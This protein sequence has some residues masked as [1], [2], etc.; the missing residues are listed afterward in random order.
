MNNETITRERRCNHRRK[1]GPETIPDNV[2]TPI[3]GIPGN[4]YKK[5]KGLCSSIITDQTH[6]LLGPS[7]SLLDHCLP[8]QLKKQ[9]RALCKET[10]MIL[11]TLNMAYKYADTEERQMIQAHRK[12]MIKDFVYNLQYI[13]NTIDPPLCSDLNYA[14]EN[15][16]TID[17]TCEE[18]E[19]I[20]KCI[21]EQSEQSDELLSI[22]IQNVVINQDSIN[23]AT[24]ETEDIPLQEATTYD[25]IQ[26]TSIITDSQP[27]QIPIEE[28]QPQIKSAPV[29]QI[30]TEDK[31]KTLKV[32]NKNIRFPSDLLDTSDVSYTLE[33]IVKILED[34]INIADFPVTT[35]TDYMKTVKIMKYVAKRI[36]L[37]YRIELSE[38]CLQ[39]RYRTTLYFLKQAGTEHN[40]DLLMCK[41]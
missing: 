35:P 39:D 7:K 10:N 34:P 32:F 38:A 11:N 1:R 15:K 2:I 16:L 22:T 36:K 24:Q 14:K 9:I 8:T 21:A 33:D 13:I 37:P 17:D 20:P 30:K 6:G 26:Y 40:I 23:M 27:Q 19:Q 4:L 5:A 25:I 31:P 28:T 41:K 29:K 3:G 12:I 18:L